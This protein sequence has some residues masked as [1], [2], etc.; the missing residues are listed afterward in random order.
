MAQ[1]SV[2]EVAG[3]PWGG[4]FTSRGHRSSGDLGMGTSTLCPAS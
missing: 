3:G 1:G 4:F 2:V